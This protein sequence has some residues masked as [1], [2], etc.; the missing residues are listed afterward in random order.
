VRTSKAKGKVSKTGESKA[1]GKIHIRASTE[2]GT[3]I[4][5]AVAW[6]VWHRQVAPMPEAINMQ[7]D[8]MCKRANRFL[9]R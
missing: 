8:I 6:H 1:K 9:V 2:H 3:R 7:A 5:V 4:G